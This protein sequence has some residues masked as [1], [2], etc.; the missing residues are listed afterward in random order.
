MLLAHVQ[1]L[2]FTVNYKKSTLWPWKQIN[3]LSLSFDSVTMNTCLTPQSI[4]SLGKALSHFQ[5]RKLVTA[6]RA[7]KLLLD[8]SGIGGDSLE[9]AEGV[10]CT[11]MVQLLSSPSKKE[12]EEETAC[13]TVLHVGPAPLEGQELLSQ[14][15]PLR[16]LPHRGSIFSTDALLTGWGATWECRTLVIITYIC[17]QTEEHSFS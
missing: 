7:Q 15:T 1:S 5:L 3:F 2:G 16:N 17:A 11:M 4:D 8:G 13:N 14:R 9:P 6:H 12:M 10:F